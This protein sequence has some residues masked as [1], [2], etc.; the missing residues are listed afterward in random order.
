MLRIVSDNIIRFLVLTLF[1][2]FVL[3]HVQLGG[4]INPYLYILFI[5]ILP[6]ETPKLLLLVL[7]FILGLTIDLFMLSPGIHAA[8]CVFMAFMRPFV[9]GTI[10]SRR[11]YEPGIRPSVQDIG[12]TWF[13]TY[14]G[15]LTLAHHFVLFFLEVFHF[16]E[17][18]IT[19]QRILYSS[20]VTL[21]V[22]IISQYVF[23]KPPK[24]IIS[25][26]I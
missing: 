1:Q 10:S 16:G 11:E 14:A 8:S 25:G 18:L 5:M 24:N 20:I 7:A 3:N 22:V 12:L 4:Y 17:I 19:L 15:I 2:V 26:K 13:L 6:F 9:I 21:I 23:Y